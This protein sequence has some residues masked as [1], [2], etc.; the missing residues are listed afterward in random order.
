MNFNLATGF[1][2]KLQDEEFTTVVLSEELIRETLQ[3]VFSKMTYAELTAWVEKNRRSNGLT[4][5]S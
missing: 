5:V 2:N 4:V 1:D 3:K